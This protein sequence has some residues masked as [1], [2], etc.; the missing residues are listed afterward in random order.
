MLVIQGSTDRSMTSSQTLVLTLNLTSNMCSVMTSPSLE[1]RLN[2]FG[3]FFSKIE[4]FLKFQSWPYGQ[5]EWADI[6]QETL[7]LSQEYFFFKN[8]FFP[9]K[10]FFYYFHTK[11]KKTI[12]G[13]TVFFFKTKFLFRKILLPGIFPIFSNIVYFFVSFFFT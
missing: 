3:I 7:E 9:S 11:Q 8:L 10:N 5:T 2:K 6:V 4:F 12:M 13:A 1:H